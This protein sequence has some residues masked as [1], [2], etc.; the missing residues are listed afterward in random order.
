M[1]GIMSSLFFFDILIQ[2]YIE[3]NFKDIYKNWDKIKEYVKN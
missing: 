2:N 3:M 1:S